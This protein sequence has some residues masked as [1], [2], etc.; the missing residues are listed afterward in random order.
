MNA[1][2]PDVDHPKAVAEIKAW[3]GPRLQKCSD[4]RVEALWRQ[5]SEQVSKDSDVW[6]PTSWAHVGVFLGSGEFEKWLNERW[7]E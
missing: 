7:G 2:P 3:C 6:K 4:A 5:F 1:I